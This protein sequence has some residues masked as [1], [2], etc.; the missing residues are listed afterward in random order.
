ML[1]GVLSGENRCSGGR[2][3]WIR[4]V[5]PIESH[6][7]SGQSIQVRRFNLRVHET[8]RIPVLLIT[9]NEK[10]ICFHLVFRNQPFSPDVVTP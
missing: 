2:T 3:S 9:C 6:A 4:T 10:D 8:Q 7:L 5:S 1:A